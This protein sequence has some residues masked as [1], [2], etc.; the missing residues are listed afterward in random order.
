MEADGVLPVY[1][2]TNELSFQR[3]AFVRTFGS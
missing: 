1:D 2:I 3:R